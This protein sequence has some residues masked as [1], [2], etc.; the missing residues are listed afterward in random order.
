MDERF[1]KAGTSDG[2]PCGSGGKSASSAQLVEAVV[3]SEGVHEERRDGVEGDG[4]G[5][6]LGVDGGV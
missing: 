5:R 3:R 4:R 1:G 2:I 6:R